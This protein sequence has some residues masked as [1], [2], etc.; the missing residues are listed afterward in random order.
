MFARLVII[1]FAVLGFSLPCKAVVMEQIELRPTREI[2]PAAPADVAADP[3]VQPAF[4]VTII[5]PAPQRSAAARLFTLPNIAVVL[6]GLAW[7]VLARRRL[8]VAAHAARR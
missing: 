2:V 6:A 7:I 8:S 1:G 3:F 5:E 4:S